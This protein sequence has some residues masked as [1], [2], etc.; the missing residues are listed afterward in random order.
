MARRYGQAE[1]I[2]RVHLPGKMKDRWEISEGAVPREEEYLRERMR[3]VECSRIRGRNGKVLLN[4]SYVFI[5]KNAEDLGCPTGTEY[6][7]DI[8]HPRKPRLISRPLEEKLKAGYLTLKAACAKIHTPAIEDKRP[9]YHWNR[10]TGP[11]GFLF[12]KKSLL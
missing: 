2:Y 10:P 11:N 4:Q 6:V 8:S 3:A 1:G 12:G 5:L 9:K 7:L